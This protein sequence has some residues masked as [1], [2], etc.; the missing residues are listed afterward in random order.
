MRDTEDNQAQEPQRLLR[1]VAGLHAGAS[2]PLAEREMILVGSGDDCD[3]VLADDGVAAHHALISVVDG[4]FQLRALDAPLALEGRTL[5]PGDPVEVDHIQRVGLGDAALAFGLEDDPAWLALAPDGQV[6][7]A[8]RGRSRV[9]PFTRR[10]P[11][12]AAVAVLCLA[13]LAIVVLVMPQAAEQVDPE[14]RLRQ[15][16]R[17]FGVSGRSIE[18]DVD[19][20]PV[21]S[22]MVKDAATRE[23]FRERVE[24]EKLQVG[25]AL[26]TGEDLAVNVGEILRAQGFAASTRY[27]GNGRVE[28]TGHFQDPAA[29]AEFANSPAMVATGVRQIVP[30]NLAD[31]PAEEA[32]QELAEVRIVAYERGDDPYLLDEAGREYRVGMFV[33]GWGTLHSLGNRALATGPAGEVRRIDV[34]PI[35]REEREREAAPPEPGAQATRPGSDVA[36]T[37][38]SR[39]WATQQVRAAANRQ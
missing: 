38:P 1:I 18:Y 12:V 29:L 39:A 10:L 28:A 24:S 4:H 35:T 21:L 37:T 5:H 16:A 2:R 36:Q 26:T 31:P 15:L 27:L 19:H 23:R 17:E 8:S 34:R 20:Q 32:P 22:G 33:P 25:L 14:Q 7:L 9:E 3:I 13:A 30:I 11:L 6:P